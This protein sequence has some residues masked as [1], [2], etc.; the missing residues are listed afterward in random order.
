MYPTEFRVSCASRNIVPM[1]SFLL[2]LQMAATGSSKAQTAPAPAQAT[3]PAK[4]TD[5]TATPRKSSV[6]ALT[7]VAPAVTPAVPAPV[8]LCTGDKT[9]QTPLSSEATVSRIEGLIY[10]SPPIEN[11]TEEKLSGDSSLEFLNRETADHRVYKNFSVCNASDSHMRFYRV[12]IPP[13]NYEEVL[14]Q[15]GLASVSQ[16]ITV[17]P[18]ES[19]R[20]DLAIDVSP[21]PPTKYLFLLPIVYLITILL[22]RW[23]NF[24]QPNRIAL[25]AE[26]EDVASRLR[27]AGFKDGEGPMPQILAA[28]Q[29]LSKGEFWEYLFWSRGTEYAGW[30]I[31]HQ[32]E[33]TLISRSTAERV[34]ALTMKALQQLA[35]INTSQSNG[36]ATRATQNLPPSA[37]LETRREVLIQVQ[38]FV[39]EKEDTGFAVLCSWQNKAFWLTLVAL[40]LITGVGST[41]GHLNLFVAGAVG[42]FLS[43]LMRQLTR[44]NVPSDYGASWATLFLSPTAGSLAGWFGCVLIMLLSDKHIG[45]LSGP[46]LAINWDSSN[47]APIIGAAFLLGFSERIFDRIV[48]QLE[49]TVAEKNDAP[50]NAAPPPPSPPPVPAAQ[51]PSDATTVDQNSLSVKAGNVC[52]LNL[53]GVDLSTV[54]S[55]QLINIDNSNTT[56]A[57]EVTSGAACVTFTIPST[58]SAGVYSVILGSASGKSLDPVRTINIIA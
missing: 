23:N 55:V 18:G 48:G 47:T 57:V 24:A 37:S 53:P 38:S 51:I 36:L 3:I 15:P 52:T 12:E 41:E 11:Q 1:L 44:A 45:V 33:L 19:L 6:S 17:T 9:P 20:V 49:N 58:T 46:L 25:H 5:N 22:V 56:V 4:A 13:G 21:R 31:G 40:I 16:M 42:G 32:A 50:K 8:P 2:L 27:L 29:K 14:N 35:D 43:R 34:D 10:L 28:T 26:L 54:N 39:Y 7:P 30:Q